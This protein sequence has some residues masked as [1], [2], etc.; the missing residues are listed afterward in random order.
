MSREDR[1]LNACRRRETDR[2]PVWIM[3]QAGRYLK[4]YREV[5][6]RVSF[7][8]LCK[9][10]ELA[11]EVTLQ[12]LDI[13][14]VDAAILFSD[15]LLILEAMGAPLEFGDGGPV[16]GG[17]VR[18]AA[19]V[20][21]MRVPDPVEAMPFVFETIRL[22]RRELA[23]RVPLIGFA[24]APFTLASYLV[25]GGTSRDFHVLKK[26]MFAEPGVLH[27]LLEKITL[28]TIEYLKAQAEAGAEALQL[29]D[30]WAGILSPG[31]YRGFALAY[32]QRITG[33]LRGS[34]VPLILFV[35][36][37]AGLLDEMK[38]AGVDVVGLDWRVDIGAA[39][40]RLGPGLAVQGNLDPCA[41]YQPPEK[42]R[43]SV[44]RVIE[45]AGDAPG[46]IFNL[47]HGILPDTPVEHAVAM[48]EAVREFGRRGKD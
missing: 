9:T 5:R 17:P 40:E 18:D 23:G 46:H 44:R 37:G 35:M 29:F 27:A 42:I 47:G 31:D 11:A 48:V 3:R 15:I 36:G 4:E 34:G 6:G 33:A 19:A 38:E 13:L 45:K 39:R 7:I 32:T 22:L 30:T 43:D 10:P 26:M 1:F 41:L 21:R 28:A 12:P 16:I 25:E 20:E 14:G 8:E 24:G 2:T